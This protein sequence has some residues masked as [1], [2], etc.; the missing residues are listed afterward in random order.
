M[1][2]QTPFF[3]HCLGWTV[4]NINTPLL[5]LLKSSPHHF[6]PRDDRS[7][8]V[9]TLGVRL[10]VKQNMA[11]PDGDEFNAFG[12]KYRDD[13]KEDENYMDLATLIARNSKCNGGHM[14]CILVR[15]SKPLCMAINTPLF[16]AHSSDVHAEINAIGKCARRGISTLGAVA[17]I[18][19]PPC[20]NCFMAL[21]AAGVQ[22]VVSRLDQANERVAAASLQLGITHHTVPD[23]DE[24]EARRAALVAE[25]SGGPEAKAA[26]EEDRRLRKEERKLFKEKKAQEK[27][28]AL[29]SSGAA[30]G[31]KPERTSDAEQAVDAAAGLLSQKLQL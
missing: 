1:Q 21:Q 16:S 24:S 17:Y 9:Q 10:I 13:L 18:T 29:G 5:R 28:A 4:I 2:F 14:G 22:R 7:H 25:N 12:W 31:G 6:L 8:R 27:A 23:C 20:K 19:M 15:E 30:S 3:W 26:I 11:L